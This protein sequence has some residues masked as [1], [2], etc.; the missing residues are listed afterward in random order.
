MKTVKK[1]G[2]KSS[3]FFFRVFF[4]SV[5]MD[6]LTRRIVCFPNVLDQIH[7]SSWERPHRKHLEKGRGLQNNREVALITRLSVTFKADQGDFFLP[8]R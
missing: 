6:N 4:K 7:V 3:F 1:L 2:K 5:E 8:S